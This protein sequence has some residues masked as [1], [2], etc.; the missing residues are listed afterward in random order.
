M[1]EYDICIIGGGI[2]GV[3]VAQ[4]GAAA[5]YRTVLLEKTKIAA[6][7]SSR[8]SKLIHGGLRY[9]ETGQLGLV[10]EA[11]YERRLLFRNAPT[12]VRQKR[13]YLPVYE[14][15]SRSPWL[16]AFG[17]SLYAL[18]AMP[19][20]L[21]RFHRVPKSQWQMLDGIKTQGLH[22]I[23]CYWDGQTDD[24]KLTEAVMRSAISLGAEMHCPAEFIKASLDGDHYKV[25]YQAGVE[26]KELCSRT[27][28]NA[29]GPWVNLLL[30][31]VSPSPNALPMDLI[32]G[33]HIIIEGKTA[34]GVYYL[35]AP[36]DRRGVLVMPWGDHTLVGTT[37]TPFEGD[38]AK[39]MPLEHEISYLLETVR[40]YFPQRPLHM[41]DSFAGLRVLPSGKDAAFFRSRETILHTETALP[42]LLTIY[43]G[44]LTVYR[45]TAGKVIKSLRSFLGECEAKTDTRYLQLK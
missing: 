28:V 11:L 22:T 17:L 42:G 35:E 23:F 24:V 14:D 1:D 43:G 30:S 4:A 21:G 19:D 18:L 39:V 27:L 40:H 33:T 10:R 6:G 41:I 26:S 36:Q 16:F 9:L 2:H 5:G 37:E 29:A 12:L 25:A 44:K 3:G 34:Q 8:S 15:T 7:T 32:Q 20:R 31:R 38:P 45:A 13:F